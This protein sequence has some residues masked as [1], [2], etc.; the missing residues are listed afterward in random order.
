MATF[1]KALANG[2]S[3]SA[4]VGRRDVMELGGLEHD[5]PR[6]F[7]L[8]CT[9]GGETHALAAALATLDEMAEQDVVAHLWR[10]GEALQDGLNGAAAR[11]GLA[12][13]VEARGLPCSPILAFKDP[14][15]RT[16]FLQETCAR[17]VLIPYIAPSFSHTDAEVQET[18]GAAEAAFGVVAPGGRRGTAGAACSKA[19]S[20]SPSSAASTPWTSTHEDPRRRARLDGPA[21][22]AQPHPPR[23]PRAGRPGAA[24]RAPRGGR[25]RGRHPGLRLA[26]GGA[27]LGPGRRS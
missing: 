10:I 4:L 26:R 11:A 21:P 9:H 16:L 24:R 25:A 5:K 22:C 15:L 18:V 14:G 7:L 6:V 3:V 1:G 23:R 17:G 19:R 13:H 2:F 27:R 8:S 20:S 12:E